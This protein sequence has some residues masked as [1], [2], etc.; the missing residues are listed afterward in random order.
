MLKNASEHLLGRTLATGWDV[1]E[2]CSRN[3]N[4]TGGTFSSCY[5]VKKNGD[6]KSSVFFLKAFD[7]DNFFHPSTP[8][9]SVM[10][11]IGE[12]TNA[13]RYE[14]DISEFCK[15]KHVTKV[16]LV[17]DSGEELVDGF[18]IPIV[19]Y[20]IFELA[21]CD[22]RHMLTSYDNTD[23]AWKFHSLH[24]VAVGLKQLHQH[25]IS[26]QD[27]KP[28][29]IL[30]YRSDSKIGDLGRTQTLSMQS[31]F[32]KMNYAGDRNYAPPEILYRHYIPDWH[33]R[34]YA[35]DMYLLGN[36]FVFY[37]TGVTMNSLLKDALPEDINWEHWRG[38]YKDVSDYVVN[39][40]NTV[41][42]NL[43]IELQ[44]CIEDKEILEDVILFIK[45]ACHPIPELRGHPK[46]TSNDQYSF[47]RLISI[48]NLL[49]FKARYR[50]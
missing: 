34:A 38:S 41:L 40:F 30:V 35:I 14:R 36:L 13:F 16:V 37:I 11:M 24:S 3:E 31:P 39:S 26:H 25:L 50:M 22:V 6:P 17:K 15:N 45:Y 32:Q 1:I 48:L 10:D 33:L 27:I 7:F 8:G 44:N 42:T 18:S 9:I 43:R 21:D 47:E 12:M 4:A 49:Y 23:L 19:P 28:S 46:S 29:N 20:L 5:K 2:K